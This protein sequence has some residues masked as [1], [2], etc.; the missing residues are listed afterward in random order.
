MFRTATVSDVPVIQRLAERIW[1]EH[2]PGIITMEQIDYMLGRMYA[3]NVIRE[4]IERQGYRYVIVDEENEPVGFIAYRF[5][6]R[7]RV[8][9][10]SKLYLL[11]SRHGRG[12]GQQMLGRVRDAGVLQGA[13]A[14]SL[15]VNK[16]NR[17]A[18]AAY[19]RFGF[20]KAEEVVTDIGGGF[21]MDDY[22]ME[23]P[24]SMESN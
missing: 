12:I 23:M 9:R 18:I 8:I 7:A 15:F 11:P 24:C 13:R 1:R 22:R 5:D 10:I 4:E 6:E 21:V 20:R 19:E 17:K 3:S 14:L 2:Y 16:N